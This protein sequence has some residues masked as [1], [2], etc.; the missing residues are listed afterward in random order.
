MKVFETDVLRFTVRPGPV[1][2]TWEVVI[3]APGTKLKPVL[4]MSGGDGPESDVAIDLL[5]QMAHIHKKGVQAYLKAAEQE[6]EDADPTQLKQMATSLFRLTDEVGGME[7]LQA[8]AAKVHEASVG[9]EGWEAYQKFREGLVSNWQFGNLKIEVKPGRMMSPEI[10]GFYVKFEVP[11]VVYEDL[12]QRPVGYFLAQ[13]AKEEVTIMRQTLQ[14][15]ISAAAQR[16]L[17]ANYLGPEFLPQMTQHATNLDRIG[18][19]I[20]DAE[21]A[22]LEDVFAEELDKEGRNRD[23]TRVQ[24]EKALETRNLEQL[25]ERERELVRHIEALKKRLAE[26]RS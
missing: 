18:R 6:F 19:A 7:A 5:N 1:D 14:M 21:L 26:R 2:G 8:L 17:K 22:R 15:G 25:K 20:G 3:E 13:I 23:E 11:G 4:A 10:M 24:L 16:F 9:R 12:M